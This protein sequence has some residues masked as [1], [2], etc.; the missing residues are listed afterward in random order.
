MLVAMLGTLMRYKIGFSFPYFN[1]KYIQE[2]HS[3]FAFTGWITHSLFFLVIAML[4]QH[5]VVIKEGFYRFVL[6]ANLVSA[7]GMLIAFFIQGYASV[8]ITFS[9]FS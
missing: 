5:L 7:Y 3:H 8:S 1:Q 4:R 6:M 2:A 9:V